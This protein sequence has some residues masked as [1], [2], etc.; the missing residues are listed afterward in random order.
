VIDLDEEEVRS[1]FS[2]Y[3]EGM[4]SPEVRD[5]VQAF[6]SDNPS[7]AAELIQYERT[8]AILHRLPAREPVIDMWA[9]IAPAAQEYKSE[10]RLTLKDKIHH[11]WHSFVATLSEGVI[12]YT[13]TVASRAQ[14][15]L[16]RHLLHSRPD[17]INEGGTDA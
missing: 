17:R 16:G 14:A 8:L 15:R 9:A 10:F 5:E 7:L 12:L 11:K 13:H 3:L 4:L 6:L 1:L 2:E